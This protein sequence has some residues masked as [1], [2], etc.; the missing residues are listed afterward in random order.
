VLDAEEKG[1]PS[2]GLGGEN[3]NGLNG[4]YRWGPS[5]LFT[6]AAVGPT[7]EAR[8]GELDTAEAGASRE[9]EMEG[10]SGAVAT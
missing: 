5:L 7:W 6:H 2:G 3:I 10:N 9:M 8:W 4:G 1:L